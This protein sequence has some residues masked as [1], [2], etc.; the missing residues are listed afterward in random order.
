MMDKCKWNLKI[1]GY[2]I[3]LTSNNNFIILGKKEDQ[4]CEVINLNLKITFK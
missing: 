2:Y 3:R 1:F 4:W